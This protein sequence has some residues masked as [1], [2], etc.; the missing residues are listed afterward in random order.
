[1]INLVAGC[2]LLWISFISL[3][4]A[5]AVSRDRVTDK[6]GK[7]LWFYSKVDGLPLGAKS[8][9]QAL[10]LTIGVAVIG[11]ALGLPLIASFV[12]HHLR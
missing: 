5:R 4:E 8:K 6:Q 1:M 10:A 2:F 9:K 7:I 3:T 12:I 11:F